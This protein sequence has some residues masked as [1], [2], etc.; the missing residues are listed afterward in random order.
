MSVKGSKSD[1]NRDTERTDAFS[2]AF[3]GRMQERKAPSSVTGAGETSVRLEHAESGIDPD[4]CAQECD[5]ANARTP[6][7]DGNRP[8]AKSK[9]VVKH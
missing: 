1:S 9:R 2:R 6:V 7:A 4:H 8:R 3:M 5:R